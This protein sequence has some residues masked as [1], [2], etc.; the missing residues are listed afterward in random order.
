VRVT[1]STEPP[2]GNPTMNFTG[3]AGHAVCAS[4]CNDASA[5]TNVATIASFFTGTSGTAMLA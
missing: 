3:L 5:A 2:G 4:A 1:W